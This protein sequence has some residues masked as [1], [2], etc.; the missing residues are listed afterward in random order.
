MLACSEPSSA[1][2][3]QTPLLMN[4]YGLRFA[5]LSLL[6]RL[7][8]PDFEIS[9]GFAG[10]SLP[11]LDFRNNSIVGLYSSVSGWNLKVSTV[12]HLFIPLPGDDLQVITP[13][14]L[15]IANGAGVLKAHIAALSFRPFPVDWIRLSDIGIEV[16]TSHRGLRLSI[17]QAVL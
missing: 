5:G 16:H 9:A 2:C 15:E 8:V 3:L 7:A 13:A 17:S 6:A 11:Y 1:Y 4:C 12:V 14:S 10:L